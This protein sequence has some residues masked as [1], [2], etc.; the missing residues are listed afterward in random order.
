MLTDPQ[1]SL[2]KRAQREAQLA[3][4][5]YRHAIETV[6]GLSGCRSSTDARLTDRHL[7]LLL[8]YIEAIFWGRVD[9]KALQ[10]SGNPAAVFRRRGFWAEK[11]RKGNTSRDRF[12][13]DQLIRQIGEREA[14]L[15]ELGCGLSYFQAIQN[16]Q[17]TDAGG[18]DLVKYLSALDRT[19][20]FKRASAARASLPANV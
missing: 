15:M 9:A 7:D 18:L 2:L 1:K 10:P 4:V 12:T 3:D 13:R 8:A 6:S 16:K 19:L 11:N 20:R 5:E 14:A 17:R